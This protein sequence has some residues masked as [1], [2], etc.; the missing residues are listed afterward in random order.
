ML[1]RILAG[2]A[3]FILIALYITTLILG[4]LQ[5]ELT[6]KFLMA[7]IGASMLIPIY[8]FGYQ[9]IYKVIK[10]LSHQN[11]TDEDSQ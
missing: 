10:K 5:N 8:L 6:Q 1:K 11:D 7:S 9:F 4:I 2:T 3:A